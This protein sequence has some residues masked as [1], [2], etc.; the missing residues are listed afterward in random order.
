MMSDVHES[1]A[2]AS[3]EVEGGDTRALD[4]Y[5]QIQKGRTVRFLMR[6]DAQ[7]RDAILYETFVAQVI[8]LPFAGNLRQLLL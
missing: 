4:I 3:G 2:G 8:E 5:R 6:G 1:N 7:R